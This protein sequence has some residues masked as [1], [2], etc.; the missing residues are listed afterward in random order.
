MGSGHRYHAPRC[1]RDVND[2]ARR[3][4]AEAQGARATSSGGSL[5]MGIHLTYPYPAY[6]GARLVSG[7]SRGRRDGYGKVCRIE[8]DHP[9]STGRMN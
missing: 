5:A 7:A 9:E 8:Y 3:G 6:D 2:G 1:C 4:Y